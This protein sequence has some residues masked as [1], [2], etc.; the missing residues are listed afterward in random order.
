ME[1]SLVICLK[2][3]FVSRYFPIYIIDLNDIINNYNKEYYELFIISY[4]VTK[5]Y[6]TRL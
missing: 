1:A 5:Y 2:S 3:F 6:Y 4:F